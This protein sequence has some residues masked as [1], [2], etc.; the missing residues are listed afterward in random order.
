MRE[1]FSDNIGAKNLKPRFRILTSKNRPPT[2]TIEALENALKRVKIHGQKGSVEIICNHRRSPKGLDSLIPPFEARK[3]RCFQVGLEIDP[4]F[5][6]PETGEVF[7]IML[8][9]LHRGLARALKK[10]FFEFSLR[11]TSHRPMHY[12]ALGRRAMVKAVWDVDRRLAEISDAFDFLLLI[13]PVNVEQAWNEFKRHHAG[14]P[15]SFYYRPLP[16]EPAL[17]KRRLYSIPM[18]RI[19]DPTLALL[20]RNK[21]LELDR[22]LGLLEDRGKRNFYYGSLQ[23]Y[24]TV[25]QELLQ[26]AKTLLSQIPPR[27]REVTSGRSLDAKAFAEQARQEI[28]RYKQ[29]YPSLSASIEIR[30]DTVGLMVSQGNL[31]IGHMTRIPVS[32]AQA[33]IQHEVGTHI[34]TFFNGKAQ[35]FQQLHCGL[36][37]YDELQEGLAVLAEYLVG[38]LSRPRVRLLAGRVVAA[39]ALTQGASFIETF[40]LLNHTYRFEQKT[41]FTISARI[42]RGGGLTKDAV[43]LR[44]FV[45]LLRYL[46]QGGEL[47]PL[48]VGKVAADHVAMIRELQSKRMT[49][50]GFLQLLNTL[51]TSDLSA[52]SCPSILPSIM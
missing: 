5:R 42:Y 15:P 49:N 7:P 30:D 6:D 3:I 21:R 36:A 40:A 19:E 27:S 31:L 24:G 25:S 20:F 12:Q 26:L 22:K 4:I 37:G 44:G 2:T 52:S 10:A 45:G 34:V 39:H 11:E 1:L 28:D 41:A 48:F 47:E 13:T 50:S 33:L 43:Y 51:S 18:E 9:R 32:R 35:P 16:V 17:L 8:R 46:H 38:G 29:V 23:L 14:R